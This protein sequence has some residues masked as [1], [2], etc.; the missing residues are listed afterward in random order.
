MVRRLAGI[1]FSLTLNA[2]IEWWGGA[3]R[4]KFADA[5]FTIAI[6]HK[7]L[8]QMREEFPELRPDQTLLGRIGVDTK[9]WRPRRGDEPRAAGPWR[10]V[11]VA[12]LHRSKGH[13][14][15]IRAIGRLLR[16]GADVTLRVVGS[17]PERPVLERLVEE[18]GLR[19]RVSFT[20]SLAEDAVIDEISRSDVF[21]LAS[22][23]EPL[24]V[25]YVE[26]MALGVPTIGTA[27]GGVAEIITD[28][29][30]G[31]LIPA[32]NAERLSAA[33]ARLIDDEFL[34]RRLGKAGRQTVERRFDSRVGAATLYER[35]TG[36]R[37]KE[38][39]PKV[40]AS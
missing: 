14:V 11:T 17:G 6:S 38:S 5:E 28:G 3:M 15:L 33:I 29:V 39:A 18:L 12:R 24:G 19:Q 22:D 30:D 26:A 7:L 16:N 2:N 8:E 37:L 9:K 20:G 21:V 40:A 25:A 13:A 4:Q 1:P 36:S 23:A 35:L 32:R 27:A 34:R 31:L 10:L